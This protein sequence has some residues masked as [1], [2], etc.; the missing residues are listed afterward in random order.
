[1]TT[2]AVF[3]ET[4]VLMSIWIPTFFVSP[5]L[6]RLMPTSD[7]CAVPAD[8]C[9]HSVSLPID[10]SMNV[11]K[12]KA[13]K[14]RWLGKSTVKSFHSARFVSCAASTCQLK[15]IRDFQVPLDDEFL[16]TF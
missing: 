11:A 5:Q 8:P 9:I 12:S 2:L 4:M 7:A 10:W 6:L 1:M 3:I 13:H 15:D 14:T 16:W